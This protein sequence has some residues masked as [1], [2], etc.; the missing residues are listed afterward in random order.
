MS[1]RCCTHLKPLVEA[2]R[3]VHT[4]VIV[5]LLANP[6]NSRSELDESTLLCAICSAFL[7][8]RLQELEEGK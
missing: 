4:H 8:I 5:H 1:D 6:M 3:A 7:I 2:E